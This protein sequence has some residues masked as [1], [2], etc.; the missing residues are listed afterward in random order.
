[1]ITRKVTGTPAQA[2]QWG[3]LQ[4]ALTVRKTTTTIGTKKTIELQRHD[5]CTTCSGTGAK[6]GTSPTACTASKLATCASHGGPMMSP[7]AKT[8][9]TLVS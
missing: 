7:A 1:V 4:V 6:P 5:R 8:P 2:G 9:F 3:L